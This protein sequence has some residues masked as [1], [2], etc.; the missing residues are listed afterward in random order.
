MQIHTLSQPLQ[1]EHVQ[2]RAREVRVDD[3]GGGEVG[4]AYRIRIARI[5][6]WIWQRAASPSSIVSVSRQRVDRVGLARLSSHVATINQTDVTIPGGTA[7]VSDGQWNKDH[8]LSNHLD[9][10]RKMNKRQ[11]L[12][13]AMFMLTIL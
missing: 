7:S 3:D 8:S 12:S 4:A 1:S 5:A 10:A 6:Q 2:T 13:S 11:L 9:K